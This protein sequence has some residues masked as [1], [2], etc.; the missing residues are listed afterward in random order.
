MSISLKHH[1]QVAL[2]YGLMLVRDPSTPE[3]KASMLGHL[4]VLISYLQI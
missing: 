4:T 3:D 2:F 1:S